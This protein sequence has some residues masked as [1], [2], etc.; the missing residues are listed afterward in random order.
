M[1]IDVGT[2]STRV[3]L[4]DLA[5][6]V[7]ASTSTSQEMM[8]PRPG[9]AEQDPDVWWRNALDNIHKTMEQTEFVAREC[10]KHQR[11]YASRKEA[12]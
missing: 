8:T 6:W 3:A 7:V 11:M 4:L 5:G 12:A 9:W 1:G 2:Q 10:Q